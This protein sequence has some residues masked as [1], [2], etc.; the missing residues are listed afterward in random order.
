MILNG[1]NIVPELHYVLSF[2][3]F[4]HSPASYR[5]L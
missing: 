2:I 3:H 1:R 4:I 5:V